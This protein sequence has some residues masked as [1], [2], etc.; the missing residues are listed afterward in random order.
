[1]VPA[2]FIASLG[3]AG[4]YNRLDLP[5]DTEVPKLPTRSPLI[6][7]LRTLLAFAWAGLA[8][9][10]VNL[11]GA[12]LAGLLGFSAGGNLRLGWDLGWFLL[13]C[14]IAGWGVA[15]WSPRAPKRHVGVL[16][17]LLLLAWGYA[18]WQL[19]TDWP[20]WFSAGLLVGLPLSLV[21]GMRRALARR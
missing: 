14:G 9:Y 8:L 3:D 1:M 15:R 20:L 5:P 18:V 13:A 19:G 12:V 4:R 21:W 2:F 7:V 10:A 16:L 17:L 6:N 11:L